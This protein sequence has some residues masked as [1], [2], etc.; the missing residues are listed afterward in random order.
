MRRI[1]TIGF[2]IFVFYSACSCE[3]AEKTISIAQTFS[4]HLLAYYDFNQMQGVVLTD[5][6]GRGNNGRISGTKTFW[7]KD[8]V[9]EGA[10]EFRPGTRVLINNNKKL[11]RGSELTI[12][13]W[14]RA[15]S[16]EGK[17]KLLSKRSYD[18]E[19]YY[20]MMAMDKGYPFAGL[21]SGEQLT[22]TPKTK[23]IAQGDWHHLCFRVSQ[24]KKLAFF[25][26]GK[27]IENVDTDMSGFNAGDGNISIGSDF[28]GAEAYFSGL[29]DELMIFDVALSEKAIE[30]EVKRAD[31]L[32]TEV[33]SIDEI[34]K[35]PSRFLV[36]SWPLNEGMGGTSANTVNAS[37][38]GQ[39]SSALKG[40][41]KEGYLQK[42]LLFSGKD[43]LIQVDSYSEI[44]LKRS[45]S[46]LCWINPVKFGSKSRIIYKG[47]PS[48]LLQF[49]V[50]GE[51]KG[52]LFGAIGNGKEN[53]LVSCNTPLKLNEWHQAGLLLDAQK[54][55]L[56]L[57]YNGKIVESI[58][59]GG[60]TAKTGSSFL[61]LGGE[62]G[63]KHGSF[64]GEI[65]D[66][67]IYKV[68]LPEE[69]F[70]SA[71][72]TRAGALE[73]AAQERIETAK[74]R[75][76]L[77]NAF[78]ELYDLNQLLDETS[79]I[80]EIPGRE[81]D[82]LKQVRSLIVK[83]TA[84]LEKR[85]KDEIAKLT[86][87]TA[88]LNQKKKA[89]NEL[90]EKLSQPPN[91]TEIPS[92]SETA[93]VKEISQMATTMSHV[94][95][96]LELQLKQKQKELEIKEDLIRERRGRLKDFIS[97]KVERLNQLN[98]ELDVPAYQLDGSRMQKDSDMEKYHDEISMMVF[99][100]EKK[101]ESIISD[102]KKQILDVREKIKNKEEQINAV[103]SAIDGK[104]VSPVTFSPLSGQDISGLKEVT[105]KEKKLLQDLTER[106]NSIHDQERQQMESGQNELERK[107]Q[108][109]YERHAKLEALQKEL[110]LKTAQ[111]I[112][113]DKNI[114]GLSLKDIKERME[115]LLKLDGIL[116]KEWDEAVKAKA[117]LRGEMLERENEKLLSEFKQT[118]GRLYLLNSELNIKETWNAPE[119]KGGKSAENAPESYFSFDQL[120][121]EE[122][123]DAM[124]DKF[125][126]SLTDFYEDSYMQG[127]YGRA[128]EFNG[129]SNYGTMESPLFQQMGSFC[130]TCW[131]YVTR[132]WADRTILL[133]TD[134][135]LNPVIEL[136]IEES[137]LWLT[138][139]T[140]SGISRKIN[141]DIRLS[142]KTWYHVGI[143][144]DLSQQKV[145][146][147]F[148]G[149]KQGEKGNVD[150]PKG[151]KTL[152]LGSYLKKKQFFSGRLDDFKIYLKSFS[153]KEILPLM[154]VFSV[155]QTIPV[156]ELE[157]VNQQ[158]GKQIKSM[159]QL[160]GE[161]EKVIQ[162]LKEKEEQKRKELVGRIQ[163]TVRELNDC[164]R[165][166]GLPEYQEPRLKKGQ[167]ESLLKKFE[168]ELK[169]RIL[170]VN[171]RKELEKKRLQEN[172]LR[173]KKMME[174]LN[175]IH[176]DLGLPPVQGVFNNA[177][178]ESDLTQMKNQIEKR[179]QELAEVE[180]QRLQKAREQLRKDKKADM[181]KLK[182]L[183]V[184][185]KETQ[186]AIRDMDKVLKEKTS[187]FEA[188]PWED[189]ISGNLTAYYRFAKQG[190]LFAS[191]S[192]EGDIL[193]LKEW[194]GEALEQGRY[195]LCPCFDGKKQY[196]ML[197]GLVY[198]KKGL[199]VMAWIK[200][201]QLASRQPLLCLK[202]PTSTVNSILL[203]LDDASLVCKGFVSDVT[204][205]LD[206]QSSFT[207]NQ[208]YHVAMVLNAESMR[209]SVFINGKMM[210]QRTL[211]AYPSSYTQ[212][213]LAL[214]DNHSRF[215]SGSIDELKLYSIPLNEEQI[216]KEGLENQMAVLSSQID[217]V[218]SMNAKLS[219]ILKEKESRKKTKEEKEKKAFQEA[220]QNLNELHRQLNEKEESPDDFSSYDPGTRL[221]VISARV[222]RL[223]KRIL[224]LKE[225]KEARRK[226]M[227][228]E[229]AQDRE[230]LK[231]LYDQ[232]DEKGGELF[233]N[234]E[235]ETEETVLKSIRVLIEKKEVEYRNRLK[236]QEERRAHIQREMVKINEEIVR[237]CSEL[238]APPPSI[239]AM[240][241]GQEETILLD[242]RKKLTEF[243][244][245]LFVHQ[246]EQQKIFNARAQEIEKIWE[247]LLP[248]LNE[249][250]ETG[251]KKPEYNKAN[252]QSALDA[253]KKSFEEKQKVLL[254]ARKAKEA[255]YKAATAEMD[256]LYEE[257][258]K[259]SAD[260][261]EAVTFVP[262]REEEV[263]FDSL[264]SLRSL[265]DQKNKQLKTVVE[266]RKKQI[267]MKMAGLH[268]EIEKESIRLKQL[269]KDL[270][271][272][273]SSEV[274]VLSKDLPETGESMQQLENQLAQLRQ[275]IQERQ[276]QIETLR[277][278]KE[279]KRQRILDEIENLK[280]QLALYTN[281]EKVI[282]SVVIGEEEQ[283]LQKLRPMVEA[284][285][286]EYERKKEEEAALK[287][288]M[289]EEFLSKKQRLVELAGSLKLSP[290]VIEETAGNESERL[291]MIDAEIMK[292]EK[293]KK[294][295]E[296]EERNR[297]QKVLMQIETLKTEQRRLH[298]QMGTNP[299]AVPFPDSKLAPDEYL[300][301]L[302]A[303]VEDSRKILEDQKKETEKKQ[304]EKILAKWDAQHKKY[305][306]LMKEIGQTPVK[307]K[308]PDPGSEI[309]GLALLSDLLDR[310]QKK[311][312]ELKA[313]EE[314]KL[315]RLQ[316]QFET[317]LTQLK[318]L[319]KELRQEDWLIP[320]VF[321]A[322]NP[323]QSI[324]KLQ[325]VLNQKTKELE[326]KKKTEGKKYETPEE[327]E[328][329]IEEEKALIKKYVH[330]LGMSKYQLPTAMK[331]TQSEALIGYFK[332]DEITSN[333]QLIDEAGNLTRCF[334]ANYTDG[335]KVVGQYG[336]AVQFNG[337]DN[338][339]HLEL[340]E[341][342]LKSTSYGM[343]FWIN[344]MRTYGKRNIVTSYSKE[345]DS[346]F[347]LYTENGILKSSFIKNGKETVIETKETLTK[348]QWSHIALSMDA[349][350]NVVLFVDGKKAGEIQIKAPIRPYFSTNLIMGCE[351]QKA[352]DLFAG[353]IDEIKIY[354]SSMN[355]KLVQTSMKE[356]DLKSRVADIDFLR[357][358]FTLLKEESRQ[359]LN[360]IKMRM[361]EA[362]QE[363]LKKVEEIRR[364]QE[365]ISQIHASMGLPSFGFTYE[366]GKE[367]SA[368]KELNKI[369]SEK[370]TERK[371]YKKSQEEKT[372]KF[373]EEAEKLTGKIRILEQK[374]G[375]AEPYQINLTGGLEE[376]ILMNA[377]A[378]L[379]Q[380]EAKEKLAVKDRAEI[381][382]NKIREDI[383]KVLDE[384]NKVLAF[385]NQ[386]PHELPSSIEGKESLVLTELI[387]LLEKKKKEAEDK[388]MEVKE[389]KDKEEFS[390]LFSQ[391]KTTMREIES[392][393]RELNLEEVTFAG[394]TKK[395]DPQARVYLNFDDGKGKLAKDSTMYSNQGQFVDYNFEWVDAGVYNKC[396]SFSGGGSLVI[397]SSLSLD[398]IENFTLMLWL[399]PVHLY[400]SRKLLSIGSPDLPSRLSIRLQ[401]EKL[402]VELNENTLVDTGVVLAK[403]VWQHLAVIF[404]GDRK[405]LRIYMNG[406]M[407]GEIDISSQSYG[408]SFML[409]SSVVIGST[410]EGEFFSGLLDEFKLFSRILDPEEIMEN[411]N[412]GIPKIDISIQSYSLKQIQTRLEELDKVLQEL[413]EK[414]WTRD[415]K[416]LD[417]IHRQKQENQILFE[418]KRKMCLNLFRETQKEINRLTKMLGIPDET[419]TEPSE[420]E[421]ESSYEKIKKRYEELI[422]KTGKDEEMLSLVVVSSN[423]AYV[424]EANVFCK[425]TFEDE[426][427][428]LKDY[429]AVSQDGVFSSKKVKLSFAS[430]VVG[431]CYR[432]EDKGYIEIKNRQKIPYQLK[433]SF[434]LWICPEENAVKHSL[435]LSR[436]NFRLEIK[437]A[438]LRV[439]IN[440]EILSFD[441]LGPL[442]PKRWVRINLI[443]DEF[444]STIQL[445]LGNDHGFAHQYSNRLINPE[446]PVY[447]CG[448]PGEP[449]AFS[450]LI[451]EVYVFHR[452]L[453]GEDFES[454]VI[455]NCKVAVDILTPYIL[456]MN[457]SADHAD[458]MRVYEMGQS[459]EGV[460]EN[461]RGYKLFPF[462]FS[463]EIKK[464]VTFVVE[465]KSRYS[466]D[467]KMVNVEMS[468]P[469]F[470]SDP[471]FILPLSGVELT[472]K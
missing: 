392:L 391:Y 323:N 395:E 87:M 44:E 344:I 21:G 58:S 212:L 259:V 23:L 294:E 51:D 258:K 26:D 74:V 354:T 15:D 466:E 27:M 94:Q 455:C 202:E 349:S 172:E 242:Y 365:E 160:I 404:D 262:G 366:P 375:I 261:G 39:L 458:F 336:F 454:P 103:A 133:L 194:G 248:V 43:D 59:S 83:K 189:E 134:K 358:E 50:L 271:L 285:K 188:I 140:S 108:E 233:E 217:Y 110:G 19:F 398:E 376:D 275:T 139:S 95:V 378:Y 163:K 252:A 405:Q 311:R 400:G 76:E 319:L 18:N 467:T 228:K 69:I 124:N 45:F 60:I 117:E 254:E 332:L 272:S 220:L 435:V 369:R 244:D 67:Q 54:K 130:F 313:Q 310:A 126:L 406:E 92:V 267:Q 296:I 34:K 121:V 343:A 179:K 55:K 247:Q 37:Y 307:I 329:A 88:Q 176:R 284:S 201:S 341:D 315:R 386:P 35:N 367:E 442:R 112:L 318:L 82:T 421:E 86:Q 25:L 251:M 222:D 360:K 449:M 379:K 33:V 234:I 178:V 107:L 158:I 148:N 191:D 255:K 230:K 161:R 451:D 72:N 286:K 218:Q 260:L 316:N 17:A 123:K 438:R 399:N 185:L 138:Y 223:Q 372:K 41:W 221:S 84:A 144:Y 424:P 174:E 297:V 460:W 182:S 416:E 338:Y 66:V 440:E 105:E 164:L 268:Q 327:L 165:F 156:E 339:I 100:K 127:K 289:Q 312:D 471:D 393:Q 75:A 98:Q 464:T 322:A 324:D 237:I 257:L 213:L 288:K 382:K 419:F 77:Q 384:L 47:Y 9:F 181:E 85:K 199:T 91:Q 12:M 141:E 5:R 415:Q 167:E 383:V 410:K 241:S 131:I 168:T 249:L 270:N 390:K 132:F 413:K 152:I 232:L 363:R 109:Y 463:Q 426:R 317:N 428:G 290:P 53:I 253:L 373:R 115:T 437:D 256:R 113:P 287:K 462:S 46:I 195:D 2:F 116:Q 385:L 196:G 305:L 362:E 183:V 409:N 145:Q 97:S 79:S 243:Q 80:E 170:Q 136:K 420:G 432:S 119:V 200:P 443:V 346:G 227:L 292:L 173:W 1:S 42:S 208:W 104:R 326:E 396:I 235:P 456:Q 335:N 81:A 411:K 20:Y 129:V 118:R 154:S 231:Q 408:R 350:G 16:V 171:E 309:E 298:E 320:V 61:C 159:N 387:Q 264:T 151:E 308:P 374:L 465:F 422:K 348:N 333:G 377:A 96:E 368:I 211:N 215:F 359:L 412:Q 452:L 128:L 192:A 30:Q 279:E 356:E 276:K 180:K 198:G 293:I 29:M 28:E 414:K 394:E 78:K 210:G 357:E 186:S 402:I 190:V 361:E 204:F 7:A 32:A 162:D 427:N 453:R 457:I 150:I 149:K 146:F 14:I 380:L 22:A 370:E 175:A 197:Q 36:G 469:I 147:F 8:G 203:L 436:G 447:L 56:S 169:E 89:L 470:Y 444:V 334:T 277:Q 135:D 342:V 303:Q 57:V 99:E 397:P 330:E 31:V 351:Y 177:T 4:E 381:E 407:A 24:D 468:R 389:K 325:E 225:E 137:N 224:A 63:N 278:E 299:S 304:Y 71:Y 445:G 157:K 240:V 418:A 352:L 193:E 49:Y 263:I 216:A 219:Q 439:L 52:K 274:P 403:N 238:G 301:A 125:C 102:L 347:S 246:A 425:M 13:M 265:V 93:S 90:L 472:T 434:Q 40:K 401:D 417:K 207:V 206:T 122:I 250:G 302:S 282:F 229:I 6:S 314:E 226:Q 155:R 236:D 340:N 300:K 153:E 430:G 120:E 429:S 38:P 448:S 62:Q 433:Q 423:E 461:Y 11:S 321:D 187:P 328:K 101:K 306:D 345:N 65:A 10:G 337:M 269:N 371:A 283:A 142:L 295:R 114:K 388:Q 48:D 245:K 459:G 266:E 353:V 446:G 281:K 239:P 184:S 441:F 111:R 209:I 280:K 3:A 166:L 106:F 214:N 273:E 143:S 355:Q 450:G 331:S 364:L 291:Q 431:K 205:L 70:S 64:C 68:C 73:R